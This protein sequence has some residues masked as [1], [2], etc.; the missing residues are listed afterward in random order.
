MRVRNI[1]PSS[2]GGHSHLQYKSPILE[3]VVSPTRDIF[4]GSSL[5][6][7]LILLNFSSVHNSDNF[8]MLVVGRRLPFL[9][10]KCNKTVGCLVTGAFAA[11]LQLSSKHYNG[12]RDLLIITR[13]THK[14]WKLKDWQHTEYTWEY[15][16]MCPLLSL[17]LFHWGIGRPGRCRML[18]RRATLQTESKISRGLIFVYYIL[19]CICTWDRISTN[20]DEKLVSRNI[21]VIAR[22]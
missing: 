19:I 7:L 3:N 4:L 22:L 15:S 18:E 10:L 12:V 8:T 20:K 5:S 2:T 13:K 21:I 6:F 11:Q 1:S 17:F 14:I 16:K 9:V